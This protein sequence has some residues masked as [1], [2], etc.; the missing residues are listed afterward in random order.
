MHEKIYRI[1]SEFMLSGLR[2]RQG[3]GGLADATVPPT[4]ERLGIGDWEL[5][6]GEWG[7]GIGD[8]GSGI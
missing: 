7:L 4:P 3:C 1:F 6:I 5:E 2:R 8:W